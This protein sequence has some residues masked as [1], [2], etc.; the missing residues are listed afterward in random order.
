MGSGRRVANGEGG[1][2]Q[3]AVN[4][5]ER[6]GQRGMGKGERKNVGEAKEQSEGNV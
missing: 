2:V 5:G 1:Y 6:D 4:M 3:G